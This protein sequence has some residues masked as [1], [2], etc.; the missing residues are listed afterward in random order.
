MKALLRIA[1]MLA[2]AALVAVGA[3]AQWRAANPPAGYPVWVM[4]TVATTGSVLDT[5]WA[6]TGY[7]VARVDL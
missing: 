1:S 3:G 2:L 5:V 6:P 7:R 4:D